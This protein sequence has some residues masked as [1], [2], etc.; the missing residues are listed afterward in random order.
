MKGRA[1]SDCEISAFAG[2]DL[3]QPLYDVIPQ[4]FALEIYGDKDV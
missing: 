1:T 4:A 3:N 2:P